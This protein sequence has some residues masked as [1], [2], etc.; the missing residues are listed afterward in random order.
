MLL[1]LVNDRLYHCSPVK[2]QT[3]PWLCQWQKEATVYCT[4][5]TAVYAA[6]V[7]MLMWQDTNL[8]EPMIQ[9]VSSDFSRTVFSQ[10][11]VTA[12]TAG[13][14]KKEV[15]SEINGCMHTQQTASLI[16]DTAAVTGWL[17]RFPP[18]THTHMHTLRRMILPTWERRSR[19]GEP[20]HAIGIVSCRTVTS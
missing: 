15:T 18:P 11:H 5:E 19:E 16:T 4:G 6:V 10:F 14:K 13:L 1:L 9:P 12:T 20:P 8:S 17:I 3:E 2:E 7:D